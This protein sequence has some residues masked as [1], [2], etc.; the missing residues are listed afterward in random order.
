MTANEYEFVLIRHAEH[1]VSVLL[2][3]YVLL[4]SQGQSQGQGHF[5]Y[6]TSQLVEA[7]YG[8][9]AGPHSAEFSLQKCDF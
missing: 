9:A 4:R 7:G 1:A 3:D 2:K 8:R 5:K 6:F